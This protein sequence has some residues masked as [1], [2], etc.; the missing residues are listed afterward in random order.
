MH[1]MEARVL[2]PVACPG[3]LRNGAIAKSPIRRN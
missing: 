3:S 1:F 2:L